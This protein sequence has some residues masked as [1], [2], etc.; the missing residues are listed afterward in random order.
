MYK[1]LTALACHGTT[2]VHAH[3]DGVLH[4]LSHGITAGQV[5]A[6]V[7]LAG[8]AVS[9]WSRRRLPARQCRL[10]DR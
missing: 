8:L 6:L 3:S 10:D 2:Q 9:M 5:L 7:A 1:Y 4:T